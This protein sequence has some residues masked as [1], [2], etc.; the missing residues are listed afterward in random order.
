MLR[1]IKQTLYHYRAIFFIV[2][3]AL[4]SI[5]GV[6]QLFA[7]S[8][9]RNLDLI[10]RSAIFNARKAFADLEAN[11]AGTMS[12]AL[13]ALRTNEIF[14]RRYL[15][16]DREGLYKVTRPL[17]ES[18]KERNNITHWY[19]I[20]PQPEKTCFLRVHAPHKYGDVI[21]RHT[22]EQCVRT[23]RFTVG[24]ELGK[25][26]LALRA[27][28]PLRHK[29]A[30]IGYMEMGVEMED[31][32]KQ[33][34]FQTGNDYA[35]L[36]KKRFLDDSKWASVAE[37]KHIPNN[38]GELPK[39]LKVATTSRAILSGPLLDKLETPE[40]LP[41]EGLVLDTLEEAGY[42]F[43]RGVF[44]FRDAS[45]RKVGGVALL[46]DI[47]PMVH[48]METQ[49]RE[50][51]LMLLVFMGIIT[52]LMLFFHKRA[53]TELKRYRTQLE[54][55][56]KERT[57]ELWET[58]RLLLVEIEEH[59]RVQQALTAECGARK[60]AEK[61]QIEAVKHAESS[62]RLASIGV[63]AAGITHEI[64]QPLNAIKVAADGFQYWHRRNPGNLPEP[65]TEQLT[66]ISDSV[67]RIVEIIQHMRAFWVM[68]ESPATTRV[69]V[70]LAIENALLLTRQQMHAHRIQCHMQLAA[71]A[72]GIK[73]NLIHLEQIIVN[74]LVNAIHALD[75]TS[76]EGKAI[77]IST[78]RDN[79][80]V[81]LQFADNGPGLP[82]T[83]ADK[84]FDPFFSTH[85]SGGG[86]G[87][88]LGLAIVK[89]YIDKYGGTIEVHNQ[90]EN[91]AVFTIHFP[92]CEKEEKQ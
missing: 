74:I 76:R 21:T 69:D 14:V 48:G 83:D 57:S 37:N 25:T 77:T 86:G 8:S 43:V 73:G 84:L 4:A 92:V 67:K 34:K 17:F 80:R 2:G 56:V 6:L 24:K 71:E 36:V 13:E 45:G 75:E 42:H 51:V 65:F 29:G 72:P 89:R 62:A 47:T 61:R 60:Q 79:G 9:H 87:M 15:E 39:L 64:N 90:E 66:L 70:H 32:L 35:L 91:G 68:P 85:N 49:E 81:C 11:A 3:L 18:L 5:A 88:G 46:K 55:M 63:M 30:L 78:S 26:A 58:N 82:T 41:E 31:F 16:D 54:E 10:T 12:A 44:P 1:K 52:F 7:I 59:K 20:H 53:E 50:I 19:F 40:L 28:H 22:F 23:G 38:W 33:L 27:V